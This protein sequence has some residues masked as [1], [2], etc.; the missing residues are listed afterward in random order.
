MGVRIYTESSWLI[1]ICLMGVVFAGLFGW[2]AV[3]HVHRM[4]SWPREKRRRDGWAK[5]VAD[6]ESWTRVTEAG[7]FVVLL[8]VPDDP[9]IDRMYR[10]TA[11]KSRWRATVRLTPAA[12]TRMEAEKTLPIRKDGVELAVDLAAIDGDVAEAIERAM[13]LE[14]GAPK[15]KPV[16]SADVG[17]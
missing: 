14:R 5:V 12:I 17:A 16:D 2:F 1:G 9:E 10:A 3:S 7:D 4:A 8:A 11:P 13:F 6:V 15:W